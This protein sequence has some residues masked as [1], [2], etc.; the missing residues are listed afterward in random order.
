MV[1]VVV[2]ANRCVLDSAVHALHLAV[3]PRMVGLCKPVLDAVAPTDAIKW[4]AA[5]PRRRAGAVL[6]QVGE[7]DAVATPESKLSGDPG[8]R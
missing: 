4:V 8:C 3:T 5:E 1:V 2:A 7:L 6:R